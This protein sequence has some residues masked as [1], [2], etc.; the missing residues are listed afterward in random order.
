MH[1]PPF[2]RKLLPL[3][4]A[5]TPLAAIA[6]EL[7]LES[8]VV[9]AAGFEQA[10]ED[11]PA[12]ISVIEREEL[13]K[14]AYHDVTDVLRDVPGVSISGGGSFSDINIRGM[15]GGYTLLLIDGR[16]QNSRETRPNSDGAGIE[17]GWLP[18][19]SAIERIEVVRGPMSSLY[20]SDAMGGVVNIITRKVPREWNGTIG[21]EATMQ[22]ASRSGDGQQG[23][24]FVGGPLIDNVLGVQLYGQ[25]SRRSEDNFEGGFHNQK[26]T[27]GTAKFSFALNEQHDFALEVG[28]TKQERITHSGR[29]NSA[30]KKHDRSYYDKDLYAFTHNGRFGETTTNTYLQRELIKNPGRD[31]TIENTEL[32]SQATTLLGDNHLATFGISAINEKLTDKGNQLK[33][34]GVD[35]LERWQLAVFAEDEWSLTDNFA[36]TTGARLTKDENYGNHITPRIY[37]VWHTSEQWTLK[38]GVSSGFKAPSLRSAVADW[39]QITGGGRGAPAVI[40]GNPDLKPE[41]SLS[42]EFGVVWN[43]RDN[44]EASV[45]LFNTD[46][47]DRISYLT[48]CEDEGDKD[49]KPGSSIAKGNCKVNGEKFKFIQDI[50]NL[51]KANLRGIETT[52]SWQATEALRFTSNYTYN[53]SKQQSGKNKGKP[54]NDTPRHTL[55]GT[56]DYAVSEPLSLWAHANMRGRSASAGRGGLKKTPSITQSDIGANYQLTKNL[57]LGAAVYNLFDKRVDDNDHNRIYDGRRYW[58]NLSMSF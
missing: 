16:R 12:S 23:Q 18:P 42:E 8:V 21:L 41:K 32:S 57:K 46:F 30:A 50:I 7:K 10:V 53:E 13:E 55:N 4:L 28:H 27:A 47:K 14:K 56:V 26:T 1:Y 25:Q 29:S 31:M 51:D 36:L 44:L 9:S 5:A 22:D 33:S 2:Q 43:N 34:K 20:G 35:T 39:G 45:T 37:G 58:L 6:E 40:Q 24:F 19:V 11:A 54:L 15:S 48:T 17:Q 49:H 52:A 38:G 3:L